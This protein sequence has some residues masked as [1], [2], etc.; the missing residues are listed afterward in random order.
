[1]GNR[2]S[3]IQ[4][5][6]DGQRVLKLPESIGGLRDVI[7]NQSIGENISSINLNMLRGETK[8]FKYFK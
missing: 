6:S 3:A 1:M 2:L 8:L 7:T 5:R 4:F